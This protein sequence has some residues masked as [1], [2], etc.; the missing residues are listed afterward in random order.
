MRRVAGAYQELRGPRRTGTTVAP[1]PGKSQT[2]PGQPPRSPRPTENPLGASSAQ[3]S[4]KALIYY[5]KAELSLRKG[6]VKTALL[7]L[8][9]AI[10]ADPQSS[11]LR[12]ALTQVEAE[13]AKQ[14]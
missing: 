12:T 5:R 4:G 1:M 9:M 14:P 2:P 13:L 8:K 10:A 7:Q 3:M 11:F 6:E